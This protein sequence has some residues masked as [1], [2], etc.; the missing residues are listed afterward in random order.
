[1]SKEIKD[2]T[3]KDLEKLLTEARENLR[4]LRFNLSGSKKRDIKAGSELR[5]DIARILTEINNR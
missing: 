5:K 1:M 3:I 2:K 4:K